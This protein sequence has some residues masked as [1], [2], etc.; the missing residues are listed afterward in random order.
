[1]N[2]ENTKPTQEERIAYLEQNLHSEVIGDFTQYFNNSNTPVDFKDFTAI[3]GFL[4]GINENNEQQFSVLF[5]V[6]GKKRLEYYNCFNEFRYSWGHTIHAERLTVVKTP[7]SDITDED[8]YYIG[9][10]VNC[11]SWAERKMDFFKDDELKDTHI[12]FG[13]MFAYAIGKEYGH[14]HSHPFAHNSTDILHGFDYLRSKGYALPW[15]GYTV[16]QL[17]S[18]GWLKLKQKG[19]EQC[20]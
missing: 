16:E 8:A 11:W 4:K 9:A 20:E 17:I 19:G 15:M 18:F 12:S 1:M 6:T 5:S 10:S 13:K 7:L 3:P 14:G 2:T